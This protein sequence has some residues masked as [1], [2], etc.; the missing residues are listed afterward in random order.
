MYVKKAMNIKIFLM[1]ITILF[2]ASPAK[3]EISTIETLQLYF[4]HCNPDRPESQRAAEA[5]QHGICYGI[6]LGITSA[7]TMN[8]ELPQLRDKVPPSLRANLVGVPYGIQMQAMWNYARDHTEL[9][10]APPAILIAALSD[11]WPCD[12]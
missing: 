9:H 10:W 7:A 4:I 12:N 6:S 8:C 11:L 5:F 2:F 1:S 3:S